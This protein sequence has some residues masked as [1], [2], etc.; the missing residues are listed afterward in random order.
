[1]AIIV[2]KFGGTSVGG[3]DRIKHVASIIE[4]SLKDNSQLV[5]VLSAMAGTTNSLIAKCN[6]F[7]ELNTNESLAEYDAAIASGEILSS[8]LLALELQ[9]L[10][11]KSR[12]L[13]GWQL[14]IETD[15]KHGNARITHINT[16]KIHHLLK[17]NIVPIITGFQ[18]LSSGGNITTLGKG[19]SD[20]SAAII[21]AALRATQCDIYTDVKGVYTA[22]PRIVHD[23]QKINEIDAKQLI[24]MCHA[25]AKVL[26][27]RA[28][29]AAMRYGF[30]LRVLSSFEDNSGTITINKEGK[31]EHTKITAI[32]SNKNLLQLIINHNCNFNQIINNLLNNNIHITSFDNK[33]GALEIMTEISQNN[34]CQKALSEMRNNG[35]IANFKIKSDLASVSI[36]GY[37]IKHNSHL[38]SQ[39]TNCLSDNQIKILSSEITELRASII[40]NDEHTE[41]AIKALHEELIQLPKT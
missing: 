9:R 36:V 33:N 34:I 32:T 23:A 11:I 8:A 19:G 2:K 24:E 39:I 20:T 13:Q 14:P 18:G 31:M 5:I 26:H 4:N 7:S 28:A 22:D 30:N 41:K 12:S 17:K 40:I 1:M 15:A 29:V 25:G 16:D 35:V 38:I 6:D 37:S 3:N 10:G 21:T 27:P